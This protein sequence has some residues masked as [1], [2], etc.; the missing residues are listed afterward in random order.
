MIKI[1]AS[2]IQDLTVARYF[3]AMD[4]SLAGFAINAQNIGTIYSIKEW[5]EGPKTVAEFD[6]TTKADKQEDLFHTSG[7]DY[8]LLPYNRVYEYD[9]PSIV[10]IDEINQ[11]AEAAIVVYK[12]GPNLAPSALDTSLLVEREDRTVYFDLPEFSHEWIQFLA[13]FPNTG[14]VVRTGT[15]DKPGIK[16]F[17]EVDALFEMLGNL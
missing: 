16:S 17:D 5:I 11:A 4:V 3:A 15:E 2:G 6:H 14:I 1:Y 12:V 13:S 9:V 10:V 7:T 8:L